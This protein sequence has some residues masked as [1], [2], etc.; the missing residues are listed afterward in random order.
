M[1][2]RHIPSDLI[3]LTNRLLYTHFSL[4]YQFLT[5]IDHPARPLHE[6]VIFLSIR[7]QHSAT[8]LRQ[9]IYLHRLWTDLRSHEV[10]PVLCASA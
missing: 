2:I 4:F 6:N 7:S 5:L 1:N 8:Y 9:L 3:Q 10:F